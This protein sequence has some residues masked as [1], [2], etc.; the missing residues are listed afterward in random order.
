MSNFLTDR[1]QQVLDVISS[2]TR[3]H[4]YPPTVREI[5]DKLGIRSGNGVACHLKS[6]ESKGAITRDHFRSRSVVVVG[7]GVCPTCGQE[8]KK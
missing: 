8:L 5:G 6:L 1:Q 3:E 4:G 7:D 2:F